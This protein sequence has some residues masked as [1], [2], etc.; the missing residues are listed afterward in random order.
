MPASAKSDLDALPRHTYPAGFSFSRIHR[1]VQGCWYFSADGSGRFDPVR[2]NGHGAC[3]LGEEDL[4][5]WVEVYRTRKELTSLDLDTR[6]LVTATLSIPIEV[7]DLTARKTLGAGITN[8]LMHGN[9]YESA[10]ALATRASQA[11]IAG[12]RWY[13]KHDAA[14]RLHAV[15]LFGP[16]G[17]A[18][19]LPQGKPRARA[20]PITADLIDRACQ[21][22]GYRVLPVP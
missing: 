16:A 20:R 17:V 15:A 9:R 18:R 6:R 21:E 1:I 4:C 14:A 2:H 5:A 19:T 8:A 12:I 10:Q 11:G 7:I 3:Y 22:F 13:A